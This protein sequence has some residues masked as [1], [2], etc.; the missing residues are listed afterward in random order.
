MFY[1]EKTE[2]IHTCCQ[3]TTFSRRCSKLFGR[4]QEKDTANE[5]EKELHTNGKE[6]VG[7]LQR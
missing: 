7:Q 3:T 4:E 6:R 2:Y 1:D 5:E